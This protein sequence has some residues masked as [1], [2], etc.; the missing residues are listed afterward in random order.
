LGPAGL[1]LIESSII[2]TA[3]TMSQQQKQQQ[4]PRITT[5]NPLRD[6]LARIAE[7]QQMT[8]SEEAA[9]GGDAGGG[10]EGRRAD[11]QGTA[12]AC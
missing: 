12:T 9:A 7:E 10:D 8:T 3:M 1:G 2:K 4:Q 6:Y 11:E 5:M